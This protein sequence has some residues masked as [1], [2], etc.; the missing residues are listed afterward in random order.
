[1]YRNKIVCVSII[2]ILLHI[3]HNWQYTERIQLHILMIIIIDPL[4][5]HLGQHLSHILG[6]GSLSLWLW[7][8]YFLWLW[9]GRFYHHILVQR[10]HS[11]VQLFA[12]LGASCLS[13]ARVV[14]C[15]LDLYYGKIKRIHTFYFVAHFDY[16]LDYLHSAL[17]SAPA[18]PSSVYSC[19]RL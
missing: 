18:W 1:M 19:W 9:L 13:L 2:G 17:D 16:K 12:R 15:L 14:D 8:V 5:V 11:L 3:L 7:L 6:F 10:I 4:H